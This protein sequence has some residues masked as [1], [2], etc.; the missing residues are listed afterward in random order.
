MEVKYLNFIEAVN[1]MKSGQSVRRSVHPTNY[2]FFVIGDK[3]LSYQGQ[4]LLIDKINL[5]DILAKDWL[6]INYKKTLSDKITINTV[7][8]EKD[9][10]KKHLKSFMEEYTG[11][12]ISDIKKSGSNI[13]KLAM[14]HFGKEL[15]MG[16]EE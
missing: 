4:T 7:G 16:D 6:I 1:V 14:K 3:M 12:K 5:D 15:I 13:Y 2:V 11:E 9:D 8:C 10:I